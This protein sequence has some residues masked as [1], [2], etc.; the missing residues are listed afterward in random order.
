MLVRSGHEEISNRVE[1]ESQVERKKVKV[2]RRLNA[3]SESHGP[4]DA[5]FPSAY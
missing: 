4:T 2:R 3:L 1:S 5:A